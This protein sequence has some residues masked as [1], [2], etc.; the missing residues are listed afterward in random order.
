MPAHGLA[1]DT[2]GLAPADRLGFE[3]GFLGFLG[4]LG[5]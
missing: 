4:F 2:G 3:A 5:F 1:L